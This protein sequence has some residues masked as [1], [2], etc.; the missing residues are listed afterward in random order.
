MAA[1]GLSSTQF[2]INTYETQNSQ[3]LLPYYH[4]PSLGTDLLNNLSHAWRAT[5]DGTERG[6]FPRHAVGLANLNQRFKISR[7]SAMSFWTQA[8]PV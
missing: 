5:I 8:R 6:H 7:N 4:I 1:R 2:I 3:F